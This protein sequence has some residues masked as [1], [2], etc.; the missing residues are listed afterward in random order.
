M[1]EKFCGID[2][3]RDT[4]VATILDGQ[5]EEKQTQKFQNTLPG[6]EC[7]KQWLTQTQCQTAVMESTGIF[8]VALYLTLEEAKF[9]VMLANAYRVKGIAGR[10][11]DQSDSEWLAYLAR[12]KLIKPSYVPTKQLR[13]LRLLT[14]LRTKYIQNRTQ[15]KNRCQ[16]VLSRVNIPIS[17]KISDVFGKSGS[18]LLEGL[19]A[20]KSV[21]NILDATQNRWL[22]AHREEILEVAMGTLSANDVFML[23]QLT[24]TIGHLN[25]QIAKVDVRIEGVLNE[26]DLRIVSSVPGVGKTS[27]ASILAELGDVSRFESGKQVSAW[28]GLAP[29]VYQS[30]GVTV[31]GHITKHGSRW[32]R[33]SLVEAAH[34]AI[35]VKDGVFRRMYFRVAQRRGKKTAVVAVARKLLTVIWHLLVCGELYVEEGFSKK[36]LKVRSDGL[37]GGLSLEGMVGVLR[38]AGYTVSSEG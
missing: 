2:V 35:K 36:P 15:Y 23:E 31:L 29:S 32:L 14:R 30:A 38:R 10:K 34:G 26:A 7:L 6:I 5:S 17:T 27:G 8:W 22:I 12:A 21:V 28:A 16:A 4:L 1:V 20:G 13:D 11:T 25:V 33:R 24:D 37:L 19:M 9:R 18:E 3:H